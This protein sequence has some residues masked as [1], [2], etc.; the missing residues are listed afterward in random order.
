MIEEN[1][2]AVKEDVHFAVIETNP[3]AEKEVEDILKN[4]HENGTDRG[5][6]IER[7]IERDKETEIDT[8]ITDV[9]IIVKHFLS[10]PLNYIIVS[11]NSVLC[12][13]DM[14]TELSLTHN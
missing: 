10:C 14:K 5:I 8:D 13:M 4:T 11:F 2:Q 12:R 1:L 3:G 9:N 7:D 6:E